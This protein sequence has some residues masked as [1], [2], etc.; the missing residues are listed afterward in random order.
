MSTLAVEIARAEARG[1]K[2]V[3]GFS[4]AVRPIDNLGLEVGDEFTFPEKYD[5]YETK[6]GTN[7]VQYIIVELTNG[8]AKPFYPSTF[9]KSRPVYNEDGTPTGQRMHTEGTAAE[10]FRKHGSV[11]DGMNALAGKKVKIPD[12]RQCRTLRYGTTE[13]MWAQM[14]TINFVVPE[15]KQDGDNA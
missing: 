9:T 8:Q 10:E 6:I 5:V 13:L 1:D 4:G 15:Q 14:P 12:M 2:K 7:T 11:N 3:G